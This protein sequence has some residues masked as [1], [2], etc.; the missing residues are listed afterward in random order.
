MDVM[1][2]PY[3]IDPV[4]REGDPYERIDPFFYN[5]LQLRPRIKPGNKLPD[6]FMAPAGAW[7]MPES[8]SVTSSVLEGPH[9]LIPIRTYRR[10]DAP[11]KAQLVWAHGGGFV[12][13]DL[14][15]P[16]A[17]A[18]CAEM[19]AR[20]DLECISVEFH[21]VSRS[22]HHY[23]VALDDIETVWRCTN[24]KECDSRSRIPRLVG[25]ASA[26]GNLAAALC[27]RLIDN[28]ERNQLPDGLILAYGVFHSMVPDNLMSIWS[29]NT[30]ILPTP[31]R[32]S[33]EICHDMYARYTGV[34][35]N[36]PRYSMPGESTPVG[37]PPTAMVCC[38]FDDLARSSIRFAK[39]LSQVGVPV[40][41]RMAVGVLHGFLNWYPVPELPQT[42]ATLDYF[43]NF[44]DEILSKHDSNF[45]Q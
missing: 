33:P 29:R 23:P 9:G 25:G 14:D 36:F 8:V 35:H 28:A 39:Q 17:H 6:N 11:P 26:G 1:P 19:A 12:E 5:R 21:L 16:E 34:D 18:F 42:L 38:E 30:D 20:A 44:V 15:L 40:T 43:A 32:F 3:L 22:E 7:S 27:Q 10:I 37:F 2:T 45:A 41:C 24:Y 31:L 4:V 13:G